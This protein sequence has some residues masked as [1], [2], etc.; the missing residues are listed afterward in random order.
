MCI[1]SKKTTLDLLMKIGYYD[2]MWIFY[3]LSA[4]MLWGITYVLGEQIYKKISI[5]TTLALTCAATAA[6]MFLL[7]F[8]RQEL[9]RD[10]SVLVNDKHLSFLLFSA[11]VIFVLA[12]IFIALSITAKNATLAGLI[13]I[14]YPVFIAIFAF[15]LFRENQLNA[16][17]FA[18]AMLIFS[19]IFVV[20]HFNH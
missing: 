12:E 4:S 19:G 18:G 8:F 20:Y 7:S 15:L 13:E 11:I 16:G 14:S 5:S 6:V 10:F 3:A 9:K 1:S 2:H 17:S